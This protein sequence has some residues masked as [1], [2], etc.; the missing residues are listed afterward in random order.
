[1]ADTGIA[2]SRSSLTNWTGR[3]ID[4]L[5]PVTAAQSAHVL[6]NKGCFPRTTELIVSESL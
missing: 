4:L 1:M 3:A 2:V 5:R 6:F